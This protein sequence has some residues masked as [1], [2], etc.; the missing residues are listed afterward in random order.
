MFTI[1]HNP[2]ILQFTSL[3]F[4]SKFYNNVEN[5]VIEDNTITNLTG[6]ISTGIA[7]EGNTENAIVK[8]TNAR[9]KGKNARVKGKN[10]RVNGKNTGVKGN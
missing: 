8:G 5:A 2:T 7:L 3:L 9:V 10:E 6:F 4:R 1:A